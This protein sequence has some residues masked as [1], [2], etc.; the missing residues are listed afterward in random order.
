[1]LIKCRLMNIRNSGTTKEGFA[2]DFVLQIALF[3]SSSSLYIV[4]NWEQNMQYV[5]SCCHILYIVFI[6]KKRYM[7]EI[8]PTFADIACNYK[9]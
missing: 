2:L 4:H 6:G 3:D 8:S 7:R 5:N 1:M 9:M